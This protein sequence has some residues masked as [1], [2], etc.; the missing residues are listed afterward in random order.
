MIRQVDRDKLIDQ[1]AGDR[2]REAAGGGEEAD[3]EQK[4]KA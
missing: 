4:V 2:R 3:V 1:T